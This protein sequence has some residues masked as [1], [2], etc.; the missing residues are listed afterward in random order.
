M[1]ELGLFPLGLVLLPTERAPLH[2]FEPRYKELIGECLDE[3]QE[4]GLVLADDDGLREIGTR[5]AVVEVLE[6]FE[7]G[8]LNI[9]VEGG[10]RFRLVRETSGR[11]FQTGEVE[12]FA[13]ED[14]EPAEAEAVERA[15]ALY[16]RVAEIAGVEPDE[17]DPSSPLLSFELGGR[18]DFGLTAK[19][20]LLE[21]RA[22][23][24]RVG[25][26][27][28][29]LERAAELLAAEQER[30]SRAATNGRVLPGD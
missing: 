12:A 24:E 25:A 14:D 10:E 22:E 28:E 17:P 27:C 15:L 18:V 4:F 29:L 13:D 19:Q 5:A 3:E 8:R 20:S 7:D 30:R 9:V 2:I 26:V 23:R 1:P 16:R 21:L 11:A 6:R